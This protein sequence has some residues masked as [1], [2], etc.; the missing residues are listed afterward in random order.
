MLLVTTFVYFTSQYFVTGRSEIL[1]KTLLFL[2]MMGK[3]LL[4]V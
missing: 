1:V 4:A 2:T 3:P